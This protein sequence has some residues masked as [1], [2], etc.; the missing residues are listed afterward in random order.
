[1]VKLDG[2]EA[3]DKVT[4]EFV[5]TSVD[6]NK[7]IVNLNYGLQV[8]YDEVKSYTMRKRNRIPGCRY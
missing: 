2:L 3:G 7:K 5:V 1:M 6:P 4:I 8:S